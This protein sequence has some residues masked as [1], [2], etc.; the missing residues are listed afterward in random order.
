MRDFKKYDIWNLSHVFALKIYEITKSFPQEEIYGIISKI[1]RATFSIPTDISEGCGRD[2]D[3]EFNRF[4]T[5]ALGS[6]SEIE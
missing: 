2:S 1:R 4:L 5:I 6:E 3:T